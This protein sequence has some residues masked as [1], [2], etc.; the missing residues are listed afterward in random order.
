MITD[1]RASV[2]EA[3]RT[4]SEHGPF[5]PQIHHGVS[6]ESAVL[7]AT[8]FDILGAKRRFVLFVTFRTASKEVSRSREREYVGGDHGLKFA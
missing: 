8:G 7:V 1:G 3:L 4:P 6:E 5:K 2:D